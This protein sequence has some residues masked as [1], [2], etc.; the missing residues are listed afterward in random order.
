[1]EK[2]FLIEIQSL[3]RT[4]HCWATNSHFAEMFSLSKKRCS[5]IIN[6]LVEKGFVVSEIKRDDTGA[7]ISR[8]LT[9]NTPMAENNHTPI[10][11]NEDTLSQ[12]T[13][14]PYPRKQGI[15][16]TMLEYHERIPCRDKKKRGNSIHSLPLSVTCNAEVT[17]CNTEIE[18]DIE[19]DTEKE[20]DKKPAVVS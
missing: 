7:V 10:P 1:M 3:D 17:E 19:K 4:N 8:T 2:L 18:I 11:G 14:I 13:G 16:S 12:E 20:K 6:K 15:E 9:V 5:V